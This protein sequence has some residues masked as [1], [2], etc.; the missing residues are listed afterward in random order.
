[1][2]NCGKLVFFNKHCFLWFSFF[3]LLTIVGCGSDHQ[4]PQYQLQKP[5]ELLLMVDPTA[6]NKFKQKGFTG[7][8]SITKLFERNIPLSIS[9]SINYK[10]PNLLWKTKVKNKTKSNTSYPVLAKISVPDQVDP[11]SVLGHLQKIP[12]ILSA[13]PNYYS[14][15]MDVPST[16]L[17]SNEDAD[18]TGDGGQ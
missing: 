9:N 15:F 4:F 11:S 18:G 14:H 12:F 13:E 3:L 17:K 7:S 5:G 6:V 16:Y 2:Q 1:M 8:R 10:Y